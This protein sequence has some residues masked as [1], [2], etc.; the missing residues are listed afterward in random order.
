M[1]ISKDRMQRDQW[2]Q[3]ALWKHSAKFACV[4]RRNP[5]T[6]RWCSAQSFNWNLCHQPE[7]LKGDIGQRYMNVALAL[8]FRRRAIF[9]KSKK[10]PVNQS[11]LSP[12]GLVETYSV[13]G[14]ALH[15]TLSLSLW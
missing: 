7:L 3:G 10:F 14:E 9:G 12:G 11:I 15:V 2:G 6:S 8:P 13:A 5:R 1:K 4:W